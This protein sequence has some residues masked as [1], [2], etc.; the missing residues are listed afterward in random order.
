MA[1][2]KQDGEDW[3][4]A[5]LQLQATPINKDLPN[6]IEILHGRLHRK[7]NVKTPT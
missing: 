6:P 2:W 4:Q 5:F 1:R 7:I 3:K